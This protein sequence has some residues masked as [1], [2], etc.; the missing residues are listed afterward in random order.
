MNLS[1]SSESLFLQVTLK[2][3]SKTPCHIPTS[4][5]LESL[6]CSKTRLWEVNENPNEQFLTLW[7]WHTSYELDLISGKYHIRQISA[8][9]LSQN[10][11][12]FAYRCG[13]PWNLIF[14]HRN[15]D[16]ITVSGIGYLVNALVSSKIRQIIM[17][18]FC[19]QTDTTLKVNNRIMEGETLCCFFGQAVEPAI[20]PPKKATSSKKAWLG[21]F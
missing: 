12:L 20:L 2:T 16:R 18:F 14:S 3:I 5:I 9:D 4:H 7:P 6:P 19:M 13:K 10:R 15:Q 8:E 21:L 1:Q 17:H 11:G